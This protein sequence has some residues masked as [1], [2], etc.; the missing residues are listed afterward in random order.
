MVFAAR[1][2]LLSALYPPVVILAVYLK[3]YK[4]AAGLPDVSCSSNHR[5]PSQIAVSSPVLLLAD[6][7]PRKM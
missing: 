7:A 2:L 6:Y 4:K 3:S 1:Y 5:S